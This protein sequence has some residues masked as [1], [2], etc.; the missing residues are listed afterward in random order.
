MWYGMIPE[1]L[2]FPFWALIDEGTERTILQGAL[3]SLVQWKRVVQVPLDVWTL[4]S[5]KTGWTLGWGGPS[6]GEGLELGADDQFPT[7]E[8]IPHNIR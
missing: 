7:T 2:G 6:F 3:E 8:T 5:N 1:E 4:E